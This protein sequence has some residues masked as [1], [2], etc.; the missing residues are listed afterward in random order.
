MFLYGRLPGL[1][2]LLRNV[3]T[4]NKTGSVFLTSRSVQADI[5]KSGLPCEGTLG[6]INLLSAAFAGV[7]SV[8]FIGKDFFF[9]PTGRAFTGKCFEML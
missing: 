6:E 1:F 9:L 8:K 2:L 5:R 7:R 4:S 3:K